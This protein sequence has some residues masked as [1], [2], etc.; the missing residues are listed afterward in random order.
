[1]FVALTEPIFKKK[2]SWTFLVEV[3]FNFSLYL[4]TSLQ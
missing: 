1:M 4:V 3:E 2:I